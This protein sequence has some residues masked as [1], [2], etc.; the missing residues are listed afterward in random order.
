MLHPI[1]GDRIMETTTPTAAPA[2][3]QRRTRSPSY[4][5]VSLRDAIEKARVFW[6]NEKR[7]SAPIDAAAKD[8]NYDVKSSAVPTT[9]AALRKYGLLEDVGAGGKQRQLRLTDSA[10]K[11]ILNEEGNPERQS[12]IKAAALRPN[13]HRE[14]WAKYGEQLPSD[15]TLRSWLLLD[16]RFN[17][18]SVAGF[19]NNYK[20][21]ISFAKLTSSDIVTDTTTETDE[22]EQPEQHLQTSPLAAQKRSRGDLGFTAPPMTANIRYLPIPLDIGDAPIPVGMSEDDFNLLLETLQ[23]W[24]KKI[25]RD[26]YHT[27]Q[28]RPPEED[29]DTKDTKIDPPQ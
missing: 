7:H 12:E 22:E 10:L 25:V 14:L 4:P 9:V 28:G 1:K 6:E 11:I 5:A 17:P 16:K 20:E 8:W 15:Q 23:L 26:D 29:E 21:T 2:P 24:K 19:I 13:L 18:A 3:K 27:Y